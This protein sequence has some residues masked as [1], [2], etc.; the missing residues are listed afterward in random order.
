MLGGPGGLLQH[1]EHGRISIAAAKIYHNLGVVEERKDNFESAQIIYSRALEREPKNEN[2]K[3]GAER[4]RSAY[5]SSDIP[6]PAGSGGRIGCVGRLIAPPTNWLRRRWS[7]ARRRNRSNLNRASHLQ[8]HP[9]ISPL[10]LSRNRN[11]RVV[12]WP[13]TGHPRSKAN[14]KRK[15]PGVAPR[16]GSCFWC[17]PWVS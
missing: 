16:S 7:K 12:R 17:W 13:G 6:G 15:L 1:S 5:A 4:A 10:T 2:A 8:S 14:R 3:Q 9:P 11:G